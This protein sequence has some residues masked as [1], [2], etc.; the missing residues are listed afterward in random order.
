MDL[1]RHIVGKALVESD[2]V[3][4]DALSHDQI[5]TALWGACGEISYGGYMTHPADRDVYQNHPAV[6]DDLT[7][8]TE[9]PDNE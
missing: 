4:V 8:P 5:E 3:D 2:E 7:V 6:R 9:L 1:I